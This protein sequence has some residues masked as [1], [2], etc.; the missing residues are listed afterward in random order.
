MQK[1]LDT[2]RVPG[3]HCP[4]TL[5]GSWSTHLGVVLGPGPAQVTCRAAELFSLSSKPHGPPTSPEAYCDPDAEGHVL[6]Y[7]AV[8]SLLGKMGKWPL[9]TKLKGEAGKRGKQLDIRAE[10]LGMARERMAAWQGA[11]LC[12]GMRAFP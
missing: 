1:G 11:P 2:Q 12:T 5:H 3:R 4:L 6:W 7:L 10:P 9:R 8:H